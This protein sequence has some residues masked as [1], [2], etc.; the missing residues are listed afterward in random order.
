MISS[1]IEDAG[2]GSGG[3][4]VINYGFSRVPLTVSVSVNE[5]DS[6]IVYSIEIV[7]RI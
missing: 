2:T 6:S 1:G 5:L 7:T 4:G 3:I